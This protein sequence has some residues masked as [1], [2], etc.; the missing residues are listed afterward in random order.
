MTVTH[1]NQF[2]ET[3]I[4]E[5]PSFVK[6]LRG[7]NSPF[8][9]VHYWMPERSGCPEIDYS[10]GRQHFREAVAVSFRPY[11]QTFLAH[12]LVA[13]FGNLG[14][15]E[16]GFIDA[17]LEVAPFGN[18][19]PR[20]TDAEVAAIEAS[21]EGASKLRALEGEMA[22]AI[23]ARKW[24]PDLMRLMVVRMLTGACGEFIGGAATM[25]A[26]LALNGSRN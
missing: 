12:V 7:A 13:M 10:W 5:L 9:C 21:S 16:S 14:E 1:S 6:D 17:M 18:V 20:L 11:A 22:D 15:M 26:R 23:A 24:L 3:P 19:P 2:A 25:M 4:S 8:P